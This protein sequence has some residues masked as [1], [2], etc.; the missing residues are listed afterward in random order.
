[1]A[2]TMAGKVKLRIP[3]VNK[4]S[5]I[6]QPNIT[7]SPS[8]TEGVVDANCPGHA[9]LTLDSRENFSRILEGDGTFSERVHDCE[10]VD[11][12]A[13]IISVVNV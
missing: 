9:L 7:I 4:M 11:K 5:A 3:A 12:A 2:S 10:E 6:S 1:M 13:K 8:L